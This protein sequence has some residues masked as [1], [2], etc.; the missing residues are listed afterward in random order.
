M[1][2]TRT[3]VRGCVSDPV[4]SLAFTD[5][6]VGTSLI[7]FASGANLGLECVKAVLLHL[8]SRFYED[9]G[10]ICPAAFAL[11]PDTDAR[12]RTRK[13]N[14]YG[15]FKGVKQC[16]LGALQLQSHA[17]AAFFYD[18][19]RTKCFLFQSA[20]SDFTELQERVHT[21][22]SGFNVAD[23]A[24]VCSSSPK[25][26]TGGGAGSVSDSGVLALLFLEL[27]LHKVSWEQV[28]LEALE[29]FRLRFLLQAIRVVNTQ[30]I[31]DIAS[32]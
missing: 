9:A 3:V 14:T 17:W 19:N 31:H 18:C 20:A 1:P 32:L 27:F 16:V 21:L 29:Y 30:D 5:T 2:L 28:P 22:L 8:H 12:T 4:A 11:A 13:A 26:G 15:A 23:V 24:F 7:K 25:V 10:V 6:V